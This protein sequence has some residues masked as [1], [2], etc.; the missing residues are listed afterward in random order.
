MKDDVLANMKR[1]FAYSN[2]V[3]DDWTLRRFIR[4]YESIEESY[5]MLANY[6]VNIFPLPF[7]TF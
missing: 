3:N 2:I 7:K 1:E 5:E 4:G 6:I